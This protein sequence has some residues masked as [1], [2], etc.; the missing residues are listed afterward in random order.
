[1]GNGWS[2]TG[3]ERRKRE[4]VEE[5]QHVV[6]L[7][8]A[9]RREL[10]KRLD[11]VLELEEDENGDPTHT[12]KLLVVARRSVKPLQEKVQAYESHALDVRLAL[13]DLDEADIARE[14]D[15]SVDRAPDITGFGLEMPHIDDAA[16][17][18]ELKRIVEGNQFELKEIIDLPRVPES[19]CK[20]SS[21][22][23]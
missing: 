17:Q 21:L 5:R 12:A 23:R 15:A 2:E 10:Q 13:L 19:S 4:L 22:S 1:M 14:A 11:V 3:H 8:R 7:T 18:Y 6:V 20:E 9:A 16:L